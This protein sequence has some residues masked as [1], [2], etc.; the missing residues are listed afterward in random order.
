MKNNE[1][2]I[3]TRSNYERIVAILQ[4]AQLE[5]AELLENELGRATIVSDENLP[6]NVVSMNSTVKFQDLESG[7]ESTVT[8]VY[9]PE[10]DIDKHKISILTPVGSAL[11]GLH[12]GQVIRWPFPT[13]KEK[14]L[15][16]ISVDNQQGV[17]S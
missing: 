8:L 13:G 2:L 9:P 4:A 10:A 11:I 7:K 3:I 16:V 15:K 1:S 17:A 6:N 14:Q 12:V 5:I